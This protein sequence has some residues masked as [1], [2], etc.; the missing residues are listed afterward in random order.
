MYDSGDT[1]L[2][3]PMSDNTY[4]SFYHVLARIIVKVFGKYGTHVLPVVLTKVNCPFARWTAD[5]IYPH[6]QRTVIVKLNV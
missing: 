4:V 5:K 2:S 6:M 3:S 1:N